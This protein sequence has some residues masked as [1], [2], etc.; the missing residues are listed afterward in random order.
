MTLRSEKDFRQSQTNPLLSVT[1]I[2]GE[3]SAIVCQGEMYKLGGGALSRHQR[4]YF[5]LRENGALTYYEKQNGEEKG[6]IYVE[7]AKIV[8]R[9]TYQ[10]KLSFSIEGVNLA[11]G[12]KEYYLFLD[13]AATKWMWY[14]NIQRLT[15]R[16]DFL[17]GDE[18]SSTYDQRIL[19]SVVYQRCIAGDA[20]NHVCADC[21]APYPTWSVGKPYGGFVCIECI[22]V[23]RNLWS[24]FC[25]EVELDKWSEEEILYMC[26]GR[27]N[28]ALNEELE[29]HVPRSVLKPNQW[30]A[31]A[32]REEYIKQKYARAFVKRP[33]ISDDGVAT[34]M[35]LDPLPPVQ[36]TA[37]R[38]DPSRTPLQCGSPPKYLG[39]AFVFLTEISGF[40]SS[41]CMAV[42]TNGFQE[43]RSRGGVKADNTTTRWNE[44]LQIG[45][46][47][48]RRPLYITLYE[49]E[50]KIVGTA[51]LILT[52][53][54]GVSDGEPK[55]VSVIVAG[56]KATA[57]ATLFAKV[58]FTRLS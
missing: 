5:E 46:D 20:A 2:E 26:E 8:D 23:H 10:G 30:S 36:D 51:E 19:D 37:V 56:S 29:Y 21:G 44:S 47:N 32:L 49:G 14:Q 53:V 34:E 25:K 41:G 24:S 52:D 3:M 15:K 48:L 54:D 1:V 45:V 43:V 28:L 16:Y 58:T 42:L 22:G 55:Q 6:I 35:L 7:G 57:H 12:V 40:A 33:I 50:N 31:R 38:D 17:Y 9:G 4:R 13:D 39:V 18:T 11:K 27:G